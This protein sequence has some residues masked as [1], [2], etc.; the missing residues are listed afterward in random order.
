MKYTFLN[1]PKSSI[2]MTPLMDIIF[3]VLIFFMVGTTFEMN[4]SLKMNLPETLTAE[5]NLSENKILLEADIDGNIAVNGQKVDLASLSETI[6]NLS[7]TE[8]TEVYI[9]GDENVP[10]KTIVQIMD[11]VKILGLE[12]ISL[13]TDIKKE[14]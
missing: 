3:L 14:L 12:Q 7:P 4:R 2:D 8:T 9:M 5:G 11:I 13:V 6:L 10:Y 1:R